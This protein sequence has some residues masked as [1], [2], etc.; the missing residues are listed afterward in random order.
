MTNLQTYFSNL[1]PRRPQDYNHTSWA[2]RKEAPN[3]NN[4]QATAIIKVVLSQS[5]QT[6]M[7]T[8]SR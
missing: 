8:R 4:A 2:A 5:R 3:P 1:L 6:M 7:I